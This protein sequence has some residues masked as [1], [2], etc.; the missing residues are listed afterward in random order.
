MRA[1]IRGNNAMNKLKLIEAILIH[2]CAQ[3]SE[4]TPLE[5][6]LDDAKLRHTPNALIKSLMGNRFSKRE[7][8]IIFNRRV[9]AIKRHSLVNGRNEVV[10][11]EREANM[12]VKLQ[13]KKRQLI[14]T[15]KLLQ[16]EIL[17]LKQSMQYI[18]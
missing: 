15:K 8:S 3:V 5:K 18:Y 14:I 9:D 2:E 16:R 13:Q 17:E 10:L 4:Y 12:I 7:E 1:V 11:K 6:L